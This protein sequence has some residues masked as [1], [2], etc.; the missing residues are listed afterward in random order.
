MILDLVNA[1]IMVS[2]EVRRHLSRLSG[3]AELCI[4]RGAYQAAQCL[5]Q[6]QD[7]GQDTRTR[8]TWVP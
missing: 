5:V 1:K 8:G 3:G 2:V 6:G 4:R 7:H